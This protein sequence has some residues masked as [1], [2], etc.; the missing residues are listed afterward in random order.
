MD[1]WLQAHGHGLFSDFWG[2]GK[3]GQLIVSS[4]SNGVAIGGWDL[5]SFVDNLGFYIREFVQDDG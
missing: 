1:C 5:E 3:R 2:A 4:V